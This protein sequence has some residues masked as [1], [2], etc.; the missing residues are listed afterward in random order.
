[1]LPYLTFNLQASFEAEK[2]RADESNTRLSEAL[3]VSEE[4]RKKLDDADRKI[5]QLQESLHR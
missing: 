1:L 5:L 4:R 3:E 2:Q